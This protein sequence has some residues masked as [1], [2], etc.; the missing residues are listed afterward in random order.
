MGIPLMQSQHSLMRHI[1]YEMYM[2]YIIHFLLFMT[3]FDVKYSI[4]NSLQIDFGFYLFGGLILAWLLSRLINFTL[5]K[6]AF[7]RV[8]KSIQGQVVSASSLHTGFPVKIHVLSNH[9]EPAINGVMEWLDRKW[10][11]IQTEYVPKSRLK[12][13]LPLEITVVG[14]T[15]IYRFN[16]LLRDESQSEY[17]TVLSVRKPD[18]MERVQR[19]Y[20][21][22][23]DL[24]LPAIVN[25]I[26]S[27]SESMHPIRCII[28]DLSGGG[29]RILSREMLG[30]Q[31]QVRIRFPIEIMNGAS[32]EARVVKCEEGDKNHEFPFRVHCE[33]LYISDDIRNN[34][35]N[36]CFN[37]QKKM[38]MK[39]HELM[40][41]VEKE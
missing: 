18:W 31:E 17:A 38:L 37:V 27:S 16:A 28:R 40:S 36:Y 32:F 1:A 13:G 26:N 4:V 9:N 35:I 21:F 7:N 2:I 19:R 8:C 6:I 20:Y 14:D 29:V 5:R 25:R 33:F 24:D 39:K 3:P 12:V 23:I 34:I 10:I 22:R 30:I 41:K 15:F 11:R